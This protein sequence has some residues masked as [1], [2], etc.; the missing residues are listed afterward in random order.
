[1]TKREK[2][3]EVVKFIRPEKLRVNSR[4]LSNEPVN[5]SIPMKFESKV[6]VDD[7]VV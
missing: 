3:L 5:S 4:S 7:R 2:E 1:M 6:R